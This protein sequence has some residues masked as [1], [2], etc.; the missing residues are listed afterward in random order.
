M[1]DAAVNA[2]G[3]LRGW[4]TAAPPGGLAAGLQKRAAE[5]ITRRGNVLTWTSSVGNAPST[6]TDL[7]AWECADSSCHL[8]DSVPVRVSIV[9]DAP[10]IDEAGQVL[11]LRHGLAFTLEFSR[12]VYALDP[13][14][15]VRCI[16]SANETNATFRF[17]QIRP[18][19]TWH[20]PELDR[21]RL[22]KMIVID[23]EPTT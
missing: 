5:G 19:Q 4:Q 22:E 21:Y 7:T 14:G 13:P 23:I 1:N 16:L 8:E 2:L 3:L 20:S 11:L 9:D 6:F 12:L 15:P 10:V 17:H 18:D